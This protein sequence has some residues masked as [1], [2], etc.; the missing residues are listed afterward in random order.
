MFQRLRFQDVEVTWNRK[1]WNRCARVEL[2]IS[3]DPLLFADDVSLNMTILLRY[4]P[5]LTQRIAKLFNWWERENPPLPPT[6]CLLHM[7]FSRACFTTC[8]GVGYLQGVLPQIGQKHAV[9]KPL[10]SQSFDTREDRRNRVL[11]CL[12]YFW[13]S[14]F[15]FG[16]ERYK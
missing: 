15:W 11:L 1:L 16:V 13:L 3:D 12:G 14:W 2:R 7:T 10:L 9:K 8:Y 5:L 4:F 6:F